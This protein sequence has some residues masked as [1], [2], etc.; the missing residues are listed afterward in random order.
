MTPSELRL[1]KVILESDAAA[2]SWDPVRRLASVRITAVGSRGGH[3]AHPVRGE[4][5]VLLCAGTQCG[6]NNSQA[7]Q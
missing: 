6:E 3:D 4:W 1:G 7:A 5:R 2:R